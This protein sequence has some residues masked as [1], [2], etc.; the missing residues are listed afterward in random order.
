MLRVVRPLAVVPADRQAR[1]A[2]STA[3]ESSSPRKSNTPYFLGAGALAFLA[4]YQLLQNDV[5]CPV[6]SS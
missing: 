3:A 2:Y 5:R 1:R 6:P 4:G